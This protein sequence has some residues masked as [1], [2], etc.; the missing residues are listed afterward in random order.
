M[1]V[2]VAQG[3]VKKRDIWVAPW[4]QFDKNKDVAA[5]FLTMSE[6]FKG[7]LETVQNLPMISSFDNPYSYTERINGF[8]VLVTEFKDGKPS[9][10]ILFKGTDSKALP[11]SLFEPPKGYTRT[12]PEI[13]ATE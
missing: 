2:E 3:T 13:G 7:F 12:A 11:P 9:H 5:A 6:F 4:E 1:R 8:P 10:E